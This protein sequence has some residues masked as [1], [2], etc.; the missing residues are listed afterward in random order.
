MGAGIT[1]LR[2]KT[3]PHLLPHCIIKLAEMQS[4]DNVSW[5]IVV[6]TLTEVEE[7]V[8]RGVLLDGLMALCH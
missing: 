7:D 8:V 2:G 1:G 4:Y 5:T 3:T 6:Y